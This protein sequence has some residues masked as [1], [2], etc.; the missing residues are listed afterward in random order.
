[1]RPLDDRC[2]DVAG[3]Q[4]DDDAIGDHHRNRDEQHHGQ[5]IQPWGQSTGFG[6]QTG[7]EADKAYAGSDQRNQNDDRK[8]IERMPAD[9][10]GVQHHRPTV[11]TAQQ[12]IRAQPWKLMSKR[13]FTITAP[14]QQNNQPHRE[15]G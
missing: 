1:M 14:A 9:P 6:D 15:A 2:L 3:S 7:A 13:N 10:V 11:D 12:R 5:Q 4:D 8:R